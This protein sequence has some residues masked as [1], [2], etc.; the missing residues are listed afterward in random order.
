[1][2]LFSNPL[3]PLQGG[4]R[5]GLTSVRAPFDSYAQA[6]GRSPL[7]TCRLADFVKA[8]LKSDRCATAIL[9]IGQ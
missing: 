7:L 1:M 9:T 5:G 6:F 2:E 8:L 3:F 4:V